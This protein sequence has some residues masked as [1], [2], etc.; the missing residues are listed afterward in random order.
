MSMNRQET[1]QLIQEVLE[2]YPEATGKQRAK[3][4]MANDPT[5]EKSNKCIVA[6]GIRHPRRGRRIYRWQ[7][8]R[9]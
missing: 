9:S 6:H 7:D 2:V 4:L 3:H 1:E 8:R 5:L